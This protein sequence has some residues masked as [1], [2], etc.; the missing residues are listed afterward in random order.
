MRKP[1]P[2]PSKISGLGGILL[3]LFAMIGLTTPASAEM[4]SQDHP[5]L[6]FSAGIL[7]SYTIHEA[8]HTATAALTGTDLTWE[9][10][11]YN[12]PLGFTEDAHNDSAGALLHASGL[13]AQ[14][15]AG[16]VILRMD[17]IDKNSNFT[18]G[19]MAWNIINPIVYALDYFI[20]GR[21][22]QIDEHGYQ[23]DI[24]GVEHYT[25]RGTAVA[26]TLSMA[27]VAIYQGVR[28]MK[29]QDWLEPADKPRK[30]SL[31]ITPV[32][33]GGVRLTFGFDF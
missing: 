27:C 16:E 7:T 18:R 5:V 3:M 13:I 14:A 15:A 33:E 30:Y 28:F 31:N 20:I 10:G 17:S 23:G 21:S 11:T 32:R 19:M 24:S 29:T 2:L 22:N 9:A 25:D 1:D 26:F 8:A 6:A 4:W 12:Q